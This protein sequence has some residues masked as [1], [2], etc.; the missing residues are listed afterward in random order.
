[1]K[2]VDMTNGIDIIEAV[3]EF[4]LCYIEDNL[5]FFTTKD[6]DKQWGDDWNDRPYE[7]N[8]SR[9]YLPHL[10]HDYKMGE[11]PPWRI[12]VLVWEGPFTDP[13]GNM[14]NSPYC[15][16]DINRKKMVPWLAPEPWTI[17]ETVPPVKDDFYNI[18]AGDGIAEFV[19][20]IYTLEGR[21]WWPLLPPSVSAHSLRETYEFMGKKGR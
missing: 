8:A 19:R 5:A 13:R 17:L 3:D 15:V 2:L 4:K 12:F 20:K 9:P 18:W 21:V 7:H 14:L 10:G 1:M 11:E 6:L 16:Y